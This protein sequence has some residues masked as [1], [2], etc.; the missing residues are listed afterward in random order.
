MIEAKII[1]DS[2]SPD[3]V[4][5]T[6]MELEYPRFIHAEFM[7]HRVF[8]RNA[9][10]S[11]AIPVAKVIEQVRTNPAMPIHWGKNQPGMQAKEE[12]DDD[13]KVAAKLLW[14]N[15]AKRAADSA[16][17]MMEIGLH[18]QAANRI[19][20]PFVNIKV[21]VTATEWDNFFNLRCHPDA[22]PEIHELANKMREAITESNPRA[23]YYG[24]WHVPYVERVRNQDGSLRYGDGLTVDEALMVS[25]SCC[26]QV[27]YRKL[28]DSLDKAKEVYKRLVESEPIHASPFEHQAR[29]TST[30][31]HG[32]CGNFN[33]WVQ[34]RKVLEKKG[35]DHGQGGNQATSLA[36][37]G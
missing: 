16:E 3:G 23:I 26:A 22:Q 15:A 11:R 10:S 2:I 13:K 8:S 37:T 27:S 31:A 14:R 18:K 5:I 28:D 17:A 4:R 7:T 24:E 30:N 29:P 1:A 32:L 21:V 36:T 20:E 9:A 6:T 12:L 35:N 25:A 19:L 34:Y 33:K